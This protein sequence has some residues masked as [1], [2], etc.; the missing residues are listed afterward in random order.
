MV[1][2]R[3]T[4]ARRWLSAR[5][6]LPAAGELRQTLGRAVCR[7]RGKDCDIDLLLAAEGRCAPGGRLRRNHR[8]E[9]NLVLGTRFSCPAA[10]PQSCARVVS[11]Y[12]RIFAIFMRCDSQ[13]PPCPLA[14]TRFLPCLEICNAQDQ[15]LAN[16]WRPMGLSSKTRIRERGSELD[17]AIQDTRAVLLR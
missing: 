6:L 16:A 1:S 3:L 2:S 7:R 9:L 8:G 14:L 10:L 12:L 17:C 11:S 5:W 15:E 4:S 13:L